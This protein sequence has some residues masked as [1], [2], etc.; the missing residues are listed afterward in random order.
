MNQRQVNDLLKF[1]CYLSC[2]VD[3]GETFREC[4]HREILHYNSQCNCVKVK[5]RQVNRFIKKYHNRGYFRYNPDEKVTAIQP[6]FK[7]ERD[8]R[9]R[10]IFRMF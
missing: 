10:R 2:V 4:L 7:G 1:W 3:I 9:Y 5:I 6:M 8:E